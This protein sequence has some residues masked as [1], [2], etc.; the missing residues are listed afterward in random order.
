MCL[1][2]IFGFGFR[3]QKNVKLAFDKCILSSDIVFDNEMFAMIKEFYNLIMKQFIFLLVLFLFSNCFPFISNLEMPTVK[4]GVL[5]ISGWDFEEDASIPLNGDWEFYWNELISPNENPESLTKKRTGYLRP[6]IIW[7]GQEVNGRLLQGTGYATY[8]AT[9]VFPESSIGTLFGLKFSTTGGPAYKIFMNET[10]I[11]EFG[12]VGTSKDNMIPTRI[13]DLVWFTVTKQRMDLILQISNFHHASGTFWYPPYLNTYKQISFQSKRKQAVDAFLFGSIFIMGFYHLS[14]YIY[15]RKDKSSLAFG[16]FCLSISLHVININEVFIYSF[17]PDITYQV[18]HGLLVIFYLLVPL[19]LFFLYSL[20]PN[21]FSKRIIQIIWVISGLEYLFAVFAPTEIGTII[22]GKSLLLLL[23]FLSYTVFGITRAVYKRR[24]ESLLIFFSNL[25]IVISAFND[26]LSMYNFVRTPITMSYAIFTFILIQSIILSKHFSKAYTDVEDLSEKLTRTNESLE[27]TVELRTSQFREEKQKAEEANLWKDK[28]ITLVSHDLRSP[29]SSILGLMTVLEEEEKLSRDE[30]LGFIQQSKVILLNSISNVGH[31]LNLSRFN[32]GI[33]T[34]E[35]SDFEIQSTLRD[36]T[37]DFQM[38]LERKNILF[39]NLIPKEIILTADEKIIQE[40]LRNLI[41]NAIKFNKENGSIVLEY[42][43]VFGFQIIIV[44]DTGVGMPD[45]VKKKLFVSEVSTTGTLEEMG[46][47]VGLK[48]CNEL[49]HLHRGTI[50]FE[51]MEGV[52]TKFFV[53]IPSNK[54][55]VLIVWKREITTTLK[56]LLE[57]KSRLYIRAN[58]I[59][60]AMDLLKKI[61]FK[62]FIIDSSFSES[63]KAEL[64][65]EIKSEDLGEEKKIVII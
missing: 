36:L 15:R 63:E 34:I 53:K 8:K 59:L 30:Q 37:D 13:A 9:I 60:S 23:L 55:S 31:L 6:G 28:F 62:T 41:L 54:N 51:S 43:E 19:Y 49:M 46:F 14:F 2:W 24:N 56:D 58:S 26:V 32:S 44:S 27:L 25:V 52:G 4:Q 48:L 65:E 47:G 17:F 45:F 1:T 29:L 38:E 50:E 12:K 7:E 33:L 22:E 40:I 11:G 3:F 21:D 20:Y 16:L 18:A 10:L 57:D 35:Y 39:E 61:S 42:K 64:I 5:D